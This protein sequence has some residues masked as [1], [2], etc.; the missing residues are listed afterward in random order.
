MIQVEPVDI[1]HEALHGRPKVKGRRLEATALSVGIYPPGR[2]R[3]LYTP[4]TAVRAR[5]NAIPPAPAAVPTARGPGGRQRPFADGPVAIMV[6][7]RIMAP[8]Q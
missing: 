7:N 2:I 1:D 6:K 4:E 5:G 3:S 8:L